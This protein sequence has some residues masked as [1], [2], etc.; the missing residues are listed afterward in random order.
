MCEKFPLLDSLKICSGFISTSSSPLNL[1]VLSKYGFIINPQFSLQGFGIQLPKLYL[2]CF[3]VD[4]NFKLP[5]ILELF[6]KKFCLFEK[7]YNS[8]IKK[9]EYIELKKII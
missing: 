2:L 7:N 6:N 1:K 9:D 4:F 8:S 5:K 3:Y